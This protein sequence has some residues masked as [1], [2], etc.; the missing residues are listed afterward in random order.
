M[1]LLK[2]IKVFYIK[3]KKVINFSSNNNES[4]NKISKIIN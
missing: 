1:L 4:F 2:I 3:L